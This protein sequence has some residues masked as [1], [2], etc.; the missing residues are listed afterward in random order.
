VFLFLLACGGWVAP[1]SPGIVS[2]ET[3]REVRANNV[4]LR[5]LIA[6]LNQR[7]ED[8]EWTPG[9]GS[10]GMGFFSHIETEQIIIQ[11][12]DWV[13]GGRPAIVLSALGDTTTFTMSDRNGTERFWAQL[14][15]DDVLT[16]EISAASGAAH[17]T[18]KAEK[19]D[20]VSKGYDRSGN[21]LS[22][23]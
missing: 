22:I 9:D 13:N 16:F 6:D 21:R 12:Q 2:P 1:T 4:E 14:D 15:D 20:I 19:D 8:P 23:R 18:I 5:Q 11:D 7:L 10:P 17:R 3:D